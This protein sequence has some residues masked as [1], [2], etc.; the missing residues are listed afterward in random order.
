MYGVDNPTVIDFV[1]YNSQTDEVTLA[2]VEESRWDQSAERLLKLQA[3]INNYLSFVLDG[4]F[5]SMYPEHS[6][7]RIAFQLSCSSLPDTDTLRFL[8]K[9]EPVL[10][11]Y[12]IRW[13]LKVQGSG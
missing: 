12:R 1:G 13:E 2:I 8:E 5:A 4:Q 3:K 11:S 10:T 7:K 9:V 6:G